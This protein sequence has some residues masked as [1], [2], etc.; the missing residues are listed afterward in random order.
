M[1]ALLLTIGVF[2]LTFLV[3]ALY[4]ATLVLLESIF[5]EYVYIH[6]AVFIIF[7]LDFLYFIRNLIRNK[8]HQEGKTDGTENK[9]NSW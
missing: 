2:I 7:I 5:G 6:V 4:T 1:G 9:D 3:P 8:Q